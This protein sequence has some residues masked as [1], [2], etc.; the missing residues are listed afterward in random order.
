MLQA[1]SFIIEKGRK[2]YK[3]KI[4]MNEKKCFSFCTKYCIIAKVIDK[5]I[6]GLLYIS[7]VKSQSYQLKINNVNS[8]A[9]LGKE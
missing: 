2:R 5:L 9:V 4:L 8:K 1:D 7:V 3:K 6:V